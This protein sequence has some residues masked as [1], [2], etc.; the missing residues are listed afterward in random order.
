MKKFNNTIFFS[1]GGTLGSVVPLIAIYEDIYNKYPDYK[2]VWVGTKNGPEKNII[3]DYNI[4]F[5]SINS[6]KLRR[7]FDIKNIVDFFNI[8]IG[9]IESLYLL[10]KYKPKVIL[11][12]GGFV[13]VPIVVSARLLKIP[14]FIHQQDLEVG[15][16]NRIMARFADTITVTLDESLNDYAKYKNKVVK[17]GNFV[18]KSLYEFDINVAKEK[19]NIKSNKPILLVLGGGTGSE[20]INNIIKNN[21]D[22]ILENYEVIH[23][24]GINKNNIEKNNLSNYH[25]FEFLSDK[26]K[27]ALNLADVIITRAGFSTLTEIC[28]LK[29]AC[30]IIPLE[31][32]QE[33]NAKLFLDKAIILNQ[34][35]FNNNEFVNILSE[36]AYN[37]NRRQEIGNKVSSVIEIGNNNMIK[38]I[39]DK[40]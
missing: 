12:A 38:L 36:L 28:A 18:R 31:G 10:I 35:N 1:G 26:M 9:F 33:K 30:I 3:K 34:N 25:V 8:I 2:Y 40:L 27:D 17:T 21:I 6:G 13:S 37:K 24:T 32:H 20:F 16:A 4:E 7:Y 23:L 15:L 19:F 29:K 22:N 11:T 5:I 14:S 39:E